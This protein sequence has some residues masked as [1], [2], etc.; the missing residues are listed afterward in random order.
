MLSWLLKMKRKHPPVSK[1]SYSLCSEQFSEDCF[2][3]CVGGKRYLKSGSV[4]KRFSISPKEKPK[5]SKPL[6]IAQLD[7]KQQRTK[8]NSTVVSCTW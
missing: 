8:N 6:I 3:Q 5:W 1:H 2:M 4:L 7:M